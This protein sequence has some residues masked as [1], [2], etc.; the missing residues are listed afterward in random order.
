MSDSA[1]DTCA[2]AIS[3]YDHAMD[4]VG[5]DIGHAID[6]SNAPSAGENVYDAVDA[7]AAHSE[8]SVACDSGS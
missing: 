1:S 2:D 6:H 4:T 3:N 8:M 5:N 7:Y